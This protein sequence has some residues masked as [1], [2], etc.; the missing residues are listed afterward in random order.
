MKPYTT[1]KREAMEKQEHL[2]FLFDW[3]HNGYD[4][5]DWYACFW[6][7][8]AERPVIHKTGTTRVAALPPPTSTWSQASEE[9]WHAAKDW[10]VGLAFERLMV[11]AFR[12]ITAPE[13]L[14]QGQEVI[15]CR[16]FKPR[17]QGRK[18]TRGERARVFWTGH[19]GTFYRNGYNQ[20][21]RHSLRVGVEFPDGSRQ[22]VPATALSLSQTLDAG[23]LWERAQSARQNY[24]SILANR[25]IY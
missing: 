11:K 6:D 1:I 25:V 19:Y 3:E 4:D 16:D 23:E 9:D 14:T 10:A 21:G 13:N 17:K 7:R 5:S 22:F 12:D 2:R 24:R 15:F 18:V 8:L 20:P